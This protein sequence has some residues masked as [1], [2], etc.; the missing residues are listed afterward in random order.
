MYNY[1]NTNAIVELKSTRERYRVEPWTLYSFPAFG[2]RVFI[3]GEICTRIAL[4]EGCIRLLLSPY[5]WMSMRTP[6][7]STAVF[8]VVLILTCVGYEQQLS[9]QLSLSLTLPLCISRFPLSYVSL[10]IPSPLLPLSATFPSLSPVS[11]S[12]VLLLISF[13][14]LSPAPPP[15]SFPSSSPPFFPPL[16]SSPPPSGLGYT[17]N[18]AY[19]PSNDLML[20]V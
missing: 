9:Y 7:L 20:Y 6:F 12:Y 15:P 19:A 11:S 18:S 14:L 2:S 13:L 3:R 1:F 16:P 17:P 5:G 8:G 4:V 10:F